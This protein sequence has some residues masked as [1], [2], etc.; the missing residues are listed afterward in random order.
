MSINCKSTTTCMGRRSSMTQ[1]AGW[2]RRLPKWWMAVG[3][4]GAREVD[5]SGRTCLPSPKTGRFAWR[6]AC[7]GR[8]PQRRTHPRSAIITSPSRSEWRRFGA[9]NPGEISLKPPSA[10]ALRRNKVAAIRSSP[11]ELTLFSDPIGPRHHRQLQR[12][13]SFQVE[14]SDVQGKRRLDPLENGLQEKPG[15]LVDE[16]L[17]PFR[18][19][20]GE[21]PSED[22]KHLGG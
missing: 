21:H 8:W 6:S 10:P 1:L 4:S 17:Q 14:I 12:T 9:V 22:R 20:V 19:F 16:R 2:R 7:A 13:L 5:H 15:E 3:R 11:A 18:R